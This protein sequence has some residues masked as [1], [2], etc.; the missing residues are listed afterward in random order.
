MAKKKKINTEY[1]PIAKGLYAWNSIHAGSFLLYIESLK[2][3]HKFIFLPGPTDYY[4]TNEDFSSCMNSN[5][6]EFVEALPDEI[7]Q[8]TIS[9]SLTSPSG[10][11]KLHTHKV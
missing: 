2:D 9:F 8:E 1:K 4:V 11:L 10:I 7:F 5:I 3:C 6:L